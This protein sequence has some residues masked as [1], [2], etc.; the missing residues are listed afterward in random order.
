MALVEEGH[1]NVFSLSNL[2]LGVLLIY[3]CIDV[4]LGRIKSPKEDVF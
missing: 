3:E 2:R 4:E 1:L